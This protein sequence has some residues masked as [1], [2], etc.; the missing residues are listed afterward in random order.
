LALTNNFFARMNTDLLKTFLEVNRT[1]HFAQA[2]ERLCLTPSAVSARIRLLEE[3]LGVTLFLRQRNNLTLSPEGERL[4]SYAPGVLETW[5]KARQDIVL[6]QQQM[7]TLN[8]GAPPGLWDS[9]AGEWARLIWQRLP[10]IAPRLEEMN[11]LATLEAVQQ[12]RLD[13]G[14]VFDTPNGRGLAVRQLTSPELRL[15]ASSP[16]ARTLQD[17]AG[18]YVMVDW[19][20][21]FATWHA[22]RFSGLDGPRA[23]VS[24][25]R[26][27]M[28]L[29]ENTPGAAYLLEPVA[30]P[31]VAEGR[32]YPVE[33][34]PAF[35]LQVY[36]VWRDEEPAAEAI[37][38]ALALIREP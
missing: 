10:A 23:R 22:R 7:Q 2:A 20:S 31:R 24:T 5:E 28:M 38:Q 4:L 11:T 35:R 30:S 6:G 27:A 25:G 19:G 15:Y 9:L 14:L 13:L 18:Q 26:L 16:G 17:V 21:A 37:T 3:Q 36:A 1:R 33:E 12:G 8:I 29:F 34:A 32:L